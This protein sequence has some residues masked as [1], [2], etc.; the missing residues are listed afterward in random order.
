MA[1]IFTRYPLIYPISP[2]KNELNIAKVSFLKT[3]EWQQN[4]YVMNHQ[5]KKKP[6][7]IHYLAH[8]KV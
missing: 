5:A 7:N 3:E 6:D 1:D 2:K 8:S 4:S